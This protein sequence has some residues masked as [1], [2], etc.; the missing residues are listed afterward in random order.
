MTKIAWESLGFL[1]AAQMLFYLLKEIIKG[2]TSIV[3]GFQNMGDGKGFDL[4][5]VYCSDSNPTQFT[6]IQGSEFLVYF[7]PFSVEMQVHSSEFS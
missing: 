5:P 1:A 7:L 4:S 2:E 6:L 3:D